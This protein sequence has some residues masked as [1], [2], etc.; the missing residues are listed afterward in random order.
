[1][2]FTFSDLTGLLFFVLDFKD[3]ATLYIEGL[4][5]VHNNVMWYLIIIIT[6]VYWTLYKI[7]QDSNWT[8]FNKQVGF[9][10]NVFLN[11]TYFHIQLL[12]L[13]FYEAVCV[14]IAAIVSGI[15]VYVQYSFFSHKPSRNLT[16]FTNFD[17]FLKFFF[18]SFDQ[19][20]FEEI[21]ETITIK[22]FF[23]EEL[24]SK[25]LDQLLFKSTNW[26]YFYF[27][28]VT[29]FDSLFA[30]RYS[31][32]LS[33]QQFKHSTLLEVVWATFPSIIILLILVPSILL[34]YSVDE[35][36][37]PEFTIKVTGH[38][39]F[40]SYEFDGWLPVTTSAFKDNA[41][42][43]LTEFSLGGT[44]LYSSFEFDSCMVITDS[45][46]LGEQRLLEVDYPL[47]VPCSIGLRFLITSADVLHAW[48]IP[49]LGIKVDAVPGRLSQFISLIRRPGVFFGQCSEICGVAHA[50]MP[51]VVHAHA[52]PYLLANWSDVIKEAETG[53]ANR[54]FGTWLPIFLEKQA[55][56]KKIGIGDMTQ[57]LKE[58][59]IGN[60]NKPFEAW[61]SRFLE[62]EALFKKAETSVVNSR[63]L[64]EKLAI[65]PLDINKPYHK[66]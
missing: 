42:I 47:V 12:I 6:I 2:L 44:A 13:M 17:Y 38:Q 15:P 63:K 57:P 25:T 9:L 49:E 59:K 4:I 50:F 20:I 55:F 7:I 62:R 32:F 53:N 40:W 41:N 8:V 18:Y 26:G 65:K 21:P 51:I 24:T 29:T 58:A 64:H 43:L 54:P 22:G 5:S 52:Y 33:V 10:R 37:D 16:Y 11:K 31:P 1:M 27:G 45:L 66:K 28:R 35:D 14:G 60:A 48:A 61:L 36:L 39:W 46:N 3:P 23:R 34:I 56:L 19:A 30:S